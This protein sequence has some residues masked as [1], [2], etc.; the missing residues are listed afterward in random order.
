MSHLSL[1]HK[2]DDIINLP[3]HVSKTHPPMDIMDRA[4][5]FSP[6]AALTGYEAAAKE[7]GRLTQPKIELDESEKQLL[8][9]KLQLLEKNLTMRPEIKPEVTLTYFVPDSKKDGGAYH[10]VSDK[11]QKIDP[12][13]RTILLDTDV[14]IPIENIINLEI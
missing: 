7:T 1:N 14:E 6:F 13:K 9:E 5:Q 11:I 8:N 3:H 4:A 2:Y 12:Y 10:T